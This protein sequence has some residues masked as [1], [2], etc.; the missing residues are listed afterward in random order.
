MSVLWSSVNKKYV[1]FKIISHLSVLKKFAIVTTNSTMLS[2]WFFHKRKIAFF[3]SCVVCFG[4]INEFFG[5]TKG[6]SKTATT[7][8]P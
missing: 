8:L 7:Q 6:Y 4:F 2:P 1:T 3:L 5:N